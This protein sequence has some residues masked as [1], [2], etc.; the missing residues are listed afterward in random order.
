MANLTNI[1]GY[2]NVTDSGLVNVVDGGLYVTKAS[3]DSIVGIISSGGSG[4]PYYLKSNTSGS[5]LIYDDTSCDARLTISSGGEATFSGNVKVTGAFKDSSGDAGTSGQILSSTATGSNWIDNDTG[6]ISGSGTANSV[7]KFTAAKVIGDGPITFATN[8]S[9]F[10]GDV[11]ANNIG[12]GSDATSFGTGVPT[13]LFKGTNSTNGRTGALYFKENDGT[14][15]AALYVTDGNDG[16]GTVL[17]AYQGSLKLATGSLTGTVLTLDQSNNATFVGD[18]TVG[19]KTYPKINLTDN[20]GVARTFSVGTNNETF[21]VRNETASSDALV[22]TN[23]NNVGIGTGSVGEKLVVNGV[24]ES[25]YLEFKPFVFYDFNSNTTSQ[26][27]SN[28]ATLS[29]PSKSITRFTTT[30]TDANINRNF[31]GSGFNSPAIP[32]GQ[33][34]IIRIRYKWISGTAGSGEIFYATSGHDYSSSYFKTYTLNTDGEFHTLVLDMSNLNAGG[35]DWIDNDITKIRFDLVN[36]TPVVIDIDWISVGGN[37][38]GTQYFENDVAFINGSVGIGA[39]SPEKKLHV[40][41]TTSDA[42]PQV[43]IQNSS[44]GDASVQYNVSGQS[45]VM[46]ID[47]DDSKKFKIASSGNL[48]STDRITLLSTGQVG[49]GTISP[50]VKLD[51][52][53]TSSGSI[54]NLMRIQNPVNSAGTGH[55]ASLILHSTT[56]ANRGVA[57]ASSSATNYAT[58]NNML[59]YTSSS[60]ALYERMRIDSNGQVGIGTTS[61]QTK[62]QTNLTITGTYLAYLNGTS[63]T[64]DAASNIAVV[65]NSPSIGSATAAGLVLANNDKSDGAPSPIIAFSAKSASNTYNHTYAAIYGIRT[66]GGADANWTKGD[67]VLATGSGTGPN[68]RM[69]IDSSGNVGIGNDG[70]NIVVTGKG[71]G[72]QNI[73]QDTTASMRLTGANATGN[74]GVATYTELKHYGEH[75]RFGI[76]HNGGTDVITINS[77]KN[78]GIGTDTPEYKVHQQGTGLQRN[79]IEC[80]NNNAGGA[81]VFFRVM[82]GASQVSNGTVTID[83]G[84]NMKFFTGTSSEAE[85]MRITSTGNVGIGTTAP[86]QK[87]ELNSAAHPTIVTSSASDDCSIAF[88]KGVG[89][90]PT[91]RIG[92][93]TSNSD[94]LSFAYLVDGYPS[95]TGSYKAVITTAGNVGIGTDSPSQKLDI[96]GKMKIS[97][98]I[99]LAQTNG[100]LDYDNGNSNGALRFHSTSGNTERMRIT[101]AGNVGINITNPGQKLTVVGDGSGTSDVV[102]IIHGNGSHTGNGLSIRSANTGKAIF[103]EGSVGAGFAEITTAYN[104]NPNIRTSGDVVAYASSDKRFK[105]NL[106]VIQNPINKIHKLNG[107]TFDWNDKQD[108]YKGKDYG[109]VAQEVEKVMPELVDT[110]FD[111]Y[112]AV[113]YEKLVPL[114]IE[115][116]KELKTEIEQLKKQI[117]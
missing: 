58:N 110:R 76:N 53:G 54:T 74:P 106:E 16:Y 104:A 35:T 66:A 34:Q 89:A 111:G 93:D 103:L 51:I 56:D 3:G 7:A 45:Y 14:D 30:G 24:I 15:T 81:G 8:D 32:G 98:D 22:I 87:L 2:F 108:V 62:L 114:L 72:I 71:L 23:A 84:G 43:L 57:I 92:R 105:D 26:W 49:I 115:S 99:I 85:R 31:D 18:V 25:P 69:R 82:N 36:I 29:T 102:R 19:G 42:T 96:V 91:W 97:D 55:G 52:V 68:E 78:V 10:A 1:N 46:G 21:T 60:S 12:L 61:P 95:L 39:T 107:Y 13:L 117:K 65:H 88:K 63:A 27:G 67:I 75:L 80:T 50:A 77:S 101:S 47:Y 59:F 83:N 33:N 90:T 113:K 44:T 109:V 6:D 11:R 4:R 73:G 79:L 41:G 17:T 94:A 20:Q 116:I 100:R 48:G 5:F 28:N 64:F 40:K 70:T 38:W 112:K 37:G 86:E 9:T